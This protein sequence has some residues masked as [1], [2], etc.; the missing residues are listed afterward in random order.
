M[1]VTTGN[2]QDWA[3]LFRRS[4]TGLDW[5]CL[6]CLPFWLES[7]WRAFGGADRPHLAEVWDG[8]DLLGLAPLRIGGR[9]V[10]FLGDPDV[11]DYQDFVVRPGREAEFCA[12]LLDHLA[13]QDLAV[14]D[15]R[16]V[17][18]ESL[19][20]VHLAP[21]ARLR[22][23]DVEQTREDVT[24]EI[25]QPGTWE[26]YLAAL[27]GKQRHEVRRK[28]RR[29][30]EAGRVDYCLVTRPDEAAAR[31]DG[32]LEMFRASRG[33]KNDFLTPARE[34]FFRSLAAAAA[35]WGRLGLGVLE[36]DGTA[37]AMVWCFEHR[38]AV[39]LYNNGYRP[40][41]RHLNV[42]TLSKVL[43]IKEA[44]SRGAGRYE[45]L[46]GSEIYKFRLGGA[47]TPVYRCRIN[48][49]RDVSA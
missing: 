33:D 13:G 41:L 26:A 10:S 5:S 48:M 1:G 43:S 38:G 27:D 7:W 3:G 6:C 31:F 37:A 17:R 15:L 36:L 16:A 22:G 14:M 49:G 20:L 18:P 30:E 11:C 9:T 47:E 35:T 12:R 4:E 44:I 25:S 46:R 21:A 40:E 23:W 8:A 34:A 24:V 42:G 28:M 2:F 19:T 45:F 32:F 29:L 39:H